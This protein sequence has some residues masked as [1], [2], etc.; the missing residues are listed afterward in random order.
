MV[1][2]ASPQTPFLKRLP[3]PTGYSWLSSQTLGDR[4]RLHLFLGSLFCFISLSISFYVSIILCLITT[5]IKIYSFVKLF[6]IRKCE[7]SN[8][9][10]PKIALTIWDSLLLHTNCRI[11]FYFWR[12]RQWN[13]DRDC[14]KPID[15]LDS[16]NILTILTHDPWTVY[17]SIY[18]C[19]QLFS[20][21]FNNFGVY[22]FHFLG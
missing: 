15:H 10:F 8:L 18:V 3:L 19:F 2:T 11:F 6:E 17:Y 1:Q 16:M 4:V 21:M 14:L 7:A 9:F 5:V 13:F 12:K 20:S 22:I